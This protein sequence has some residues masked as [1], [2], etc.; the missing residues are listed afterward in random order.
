LPAVELRG[1]RFGFL[2]G[3]V[4]QDRDVNLDTFRWMLQEFRAR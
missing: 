1:H 2:F 4:R 3:N